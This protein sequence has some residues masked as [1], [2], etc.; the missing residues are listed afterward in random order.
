MFTMKLP[1]NSKRGE[2]SLNDLN[3]RLQPQPIYY[4]VAQ[5]SDGSTSP[6]TAHE[7]EPRGQRSDPSTTRYLLIELVIVTAGVLLALSVDSFR[8]WT[9]GRALVREARERIRQEI[10][11]NLKELDEVLGSMQTRREGLTNAIRLADDLTSTK[12][13]SI[14]SLQL[15]V[16]VADL[17]KASF[18]S[19][20]RT[21]AMAQMS[22]VEVQ[23]YSELY[24]LQDVFTDLNR[25]SLEHVT[26]ALAMVRGDPYLARADDLEALRTQ[27]IAALGDLTVE[28]QMGQRLLT[29]YREATA[30][31]QR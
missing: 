25:R 17:P 2:P 4:G 29:A 10:A 31:P 1:P 16:V 20:E 27:A 28:E 3:Y 19:A 21:G 9:Q 30:S 5:M 24:A 8:Q 6:V 26:S 13:S 23:N 22:Y 7:P 14:R 12:T 18:Q 15:D 11:D